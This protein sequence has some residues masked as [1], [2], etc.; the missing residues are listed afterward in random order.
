MSTGSSSSGCWVERHEINALRNIGLCRSSHHSDDCFTLS[1]LQS[2]LHDWRSLNDF[3]SW[4]Y[5][6]F[7]HKYNYID[8]C[9][10]WMRLG[11]RG[12]VHDAWECH[13]MPHRGTRGGSFNCTSSGF[14][15]LYGWSVSSILTCPKYI[16]TNSLPTCS[17]ISVPISNTLFNKVFHNNVMSLALTAGQKTLVLLDPT[18]A[19]LFVDREHVPTIVNALTESIRS[20]FVF[21]LCCMGVSAA[22]FFLVPWT[23]LIRIKTRPSR[24]SV[25]AIARTDFILPPPGK[26]ERKKKYHTV[27][28]FE[29]LDHWMG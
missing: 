16:H 14:F 20:T 9:S 11:S 13:A 5:P 4:T 2:I 18:R 3:G 7:R 27:D 1:I 10:L 25:M 6:S 24:I 12:W 22:F 15:F 17:T 21:G 23:P 26:L 29:D 28:F 8:T 19:S